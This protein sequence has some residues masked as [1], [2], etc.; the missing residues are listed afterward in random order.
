MAEKAG[1][2]AALPDVRDL[3]RLATQVDRLVADIGKLRANSLENPVRLSTK[4]ASLEKAASEFSMFDRIGEQLSVFV[5]EARRGLEETIR[6][7]HA[8]FGVELEPLLHELGLKLT[9]QYPDLKAGLFSLEL[10]LERGEVKV[11]FG[12]KQELLGRSQASTTKVASFLQ[13][14]LNELGSSADDDQFAAIL[15]S[16]Y[17]RAYAD[18]ERGI[19][20]TQ[21]LPILAL[22]VQSQR[23]SDDPRREH[24]R[25][26]GRAD[27]AYDLFRHRSSLQDAGVHLRVAAR[28]ETRRRRDFLWVPED[29]AGRGSSYSRIEI[30]GT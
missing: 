26:Y 9:G 23:F 28:A 24:F 5:D 18:E 15:T 3:K 12:P 21:L 27:L 30:K 16:T 6:N 10:E 11:W 20:L 14:K 29:P 1:H 17:H 22:A 2:E 25:D 4:L 19:P 8:R 13:G 7:S